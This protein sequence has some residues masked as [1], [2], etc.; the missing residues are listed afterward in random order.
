MSSLFLS[1]P[2]SRHFEVRY[3]ENK[4]YELKFGNSVNGKKLNLNDTVAIYYLKSNG[5]LV[6]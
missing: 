3:N 2:N 6:K 4:N 1:E 5:R